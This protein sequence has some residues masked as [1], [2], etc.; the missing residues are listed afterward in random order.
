MAAIVPTKYAPDSVN[1]LKDLLRGHNKVK[2]AGRVILC[3][4]PN[5]H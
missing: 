3:V 5:P 4:P 1:D 2:V